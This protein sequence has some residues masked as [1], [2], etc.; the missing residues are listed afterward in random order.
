MHFSFS[1]GGGGVDACSTYNYGVFF[2]TALLC[3]IFCIFYNCMLNCKLP[4]SANVKTLM[5]FD[6]AP[7]SSH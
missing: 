2:I 3:F 1:V 7:Q 6:V 4:A 5:G